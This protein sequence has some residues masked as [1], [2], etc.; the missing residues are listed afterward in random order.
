MVEVAGAGQE[1]KWL[2]KGEI[3]TNY[4]GLWKL[5]GRFGFGSISNGEPQKV[6]KERDM[7]RSLYSRD[8]LSNWQLIRLYVNDCHVS[9]NWNSILLMVWFFQLLVHRTNWL[10]L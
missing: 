6:S 2:A 10:S 9:E 3:M 4:E 7:S 5:C 8:S 1:S